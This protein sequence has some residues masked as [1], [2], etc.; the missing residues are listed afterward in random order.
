MPG[1]SV[2]FFGV[3][4]RY[5]AFDVN[6]TACVELDAVSL[7][8]LPDMLAGASRL[9]EKFVGVYE[10]IE[11]R[12]CIRECRGLL[13]GRRFGAKPPPYRHRI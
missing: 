6:T 4:D 12:S 5:F 9:R 1:L 10:P 13:R 7:S 8:I 11:L 2:H 3:R